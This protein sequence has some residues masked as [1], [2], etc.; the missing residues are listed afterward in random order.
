MR[1]QTHQLKLI[2]SNAP[3]DEDEIGANVAIAMILPFSG[4]G[5]I[6]ETLRQ[7]P[8][9]LQKFQSASEQSIEILAENP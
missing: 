1:P 9:H 2:S 3:I 4:E 5:M 8:I 7:R 6:A